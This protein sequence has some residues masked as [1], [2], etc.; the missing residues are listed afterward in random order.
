MEQHLATMRTLYDCG[1]VD[2]GGPFEDESGGLVIF[3]ATSEHDVIA[4]METDPAVLAGV[5]SF[6]I[7]R[8]HAVFDR[9]HGI[10]A[11]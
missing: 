7:K 1:S 9:A 5:L 4:A 3:E 10:A 11:G 2:V 8:L 6:D